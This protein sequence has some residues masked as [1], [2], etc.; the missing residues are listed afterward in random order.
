MHEARE[1]GDRRR[2]VVAMGA[3]E[4]L[5]RRRYSR[6]VVRMMGFW[7]MAGEGVSR[8]VRAG[9]IG[10]RGSGLVAE[11]VGVRSDVLFRGGRRHT[12]SLPA[13]GLPSEGTGSALRSRRRAGLNGRIVDEPVSSSGCQGRAASIS[14][15][16]P[17]RHPVEMLAS[18]AGCR[19]PV[20]DDGAAVEC[21]STGY[22]ARRTAC[23]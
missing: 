7:S 22:D 19:H 12:P 2:A 21:S 8:L 9:Q 23:R 5:E 18:T 3:L 15:Q 13:A 17:G 20:P 16:M 14:M 4:R 6:S 11:S 1:V 10:G